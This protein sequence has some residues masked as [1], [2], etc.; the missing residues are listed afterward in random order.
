MSITGA[1]DRNVGWPRVAASFE[2]HRPLK[3]EDEFEIWIRITAI[4][5]KS[6]K[7]SCFLIKDEIRYA[8]GSMTITCVEK[9][10]DGTFK[11]QPIPS[12]IAS[13]FEVAPELETGR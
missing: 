4:N 6:I 7:Y 5:D 2:F 8:T 12:D 3:F 10:A 1:A 9:L 13:L 11:S